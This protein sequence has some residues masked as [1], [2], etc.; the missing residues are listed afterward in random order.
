M[1]QRNRFATLDLK[2]FVDSF[3]LVLSIFIFS[4]FA[5]QERDE[6]I[7]RGVSYSGKALPI[8]VRY[9]LFK[10]GY[11]YSEVVSDIQMKFELFKCDV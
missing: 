2:A 10:K 3:K 5:F 4:G 9:E 11:I 6:L 1:F 7:K 8:Q